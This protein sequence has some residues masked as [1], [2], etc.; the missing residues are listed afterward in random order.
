MDISAQ[1]QGDDSPSENIPQGPGIHV[2]LDEC[3]NYASWQNSVPF[4]KSLEVQNPA[5]ETLTDL[6]LSMH[7]EPEFARPKQWRFERIAPGTSI[8]VNDLLVDLDPS[9]LNGLNEAERGQVR[10][11]LQQG[12]TLLAERIKEVRVLA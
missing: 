5:A 9:Y 4:L 8:K 12:E 11:S 6:V 7:T 3:L 1:N 10:F 2:A